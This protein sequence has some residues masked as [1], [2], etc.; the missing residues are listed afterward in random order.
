MVRYEDLI[1]IPQE[2]RVPFRWPKLMAGSMYLFYV[3]VIIR[4]PPIVRQLLQQDKIR[5]EGQLMM[6]FTLLFL[7]V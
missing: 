7:S 2:H 6:D 4:P 1:R 5:N 3:Y